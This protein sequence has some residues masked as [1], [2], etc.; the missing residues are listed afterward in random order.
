M[1][2]LRIGERIKNL[3]KASNL[4]QEELAERAGLTKGFIS[5]IERDLTSISVD[6]LAQLLDALDETLADFFRD[7]VDPKIIF[8]KSDRRQLNK[9]GMKAFELL[10]K[11]A[12][13]RQMDPVICTLA[14]G[15]STFIDEPHEG[16]EFGFVLQGRISIFWGD[17]EYRAKKDECFYYECDRE[18][19]ITNTGRKNA[20]FLWISSPPY[21]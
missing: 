19:Y 20:T 14:P 3:R 10:I 5:Q 9:D 18:H 21:F 2:S 7:T 13:N 12:Q 6:S 16:E 11:G 15:E 1:D 8:C 4:T 17:K